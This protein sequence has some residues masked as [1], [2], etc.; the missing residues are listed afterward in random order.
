MKAKHPYLFQITHGLIITVK[1]YKPR[2]NDFK[3]L[4]NI[5]IEPYRSIFTS[6]LQEY[7]RIIQNKKRQ[8]KL[9]NREQLRAFDSDKPSDFW[10]LWH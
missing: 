6:L 4:N 3:Q 2:I 9:N 10:K 5:D 1:L 7:K 8:Y